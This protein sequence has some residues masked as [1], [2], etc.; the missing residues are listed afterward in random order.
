[1]KTILHAVMALVGAACLF[2]AQTLAA[3]DAL[4]PWLIGIEV[5]KLDTEGDADV[6]DAYTGTLVLDRNL[7]KI[8]SLEGSLTFIPRLTGNTYIDYASGAP[9][10]VNRLKA[11]TG[12]T[13]TWAAGVAV[14][15]LYHLAPQLR[16]CHP[17]LSAGL[18]VLKYGEE[19]GE[20]D[21][22][23]VTPRVGAGIIQPITDRLALRADF[24]YF[25]SGSFLKSESNAKLDVGIAYTLGATKRA[26]LPSAGLQP[27]PA[28][29]QHEEPS[30]TPPQAVQ[31]YDRELHELHIEFAPGSST[32]EAQY[33]EQLDVIGKILKD[34]PAAT[35]TI[36]GHCDQRRGD[37][38]QE[39]MDLTKKRAEAVR[40]YLAGGKW[41]IAR[42]RMEIAGRGFSQPKEAADLDKG[43]IANRRIVITISRP[44][45]P[46]TRN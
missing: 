12:E 3:D 30:A 44:V 46:S 4:K 42:T 11:K 15:A 21:G 27:A 34:T 10:S 19:V 18:G 17:Y 7:S 25:I 45:M 38:E 39:V 2:R 43:N 35:A 32:L 31:V 28:A 1:M 6:D 20:N 16:C 26:V 24:R 33:Y 41:K 23:D 13:D 37:S 36:E 14:D 8:F 22:L 9:V 40:D 5:G 29:G